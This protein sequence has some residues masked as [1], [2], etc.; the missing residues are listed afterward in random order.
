MRWGLGPVFYYE[1]LLMSRRW[2]VYAARALFLLIV[3]AALFLVGLAHVAEHPHP[4]LQDEA[5]VGERFFYA[6]I[7][8]QLVLVLL[9]A[10]AATAGSVCLDK[11]RGTLDHLL[12]TDLSDSEIVLGKLAARLLPVLGL[13]A[14]TLP[15]MALNTLLGGID[16]LALA[17]A[18]LI[19]VGVAVLGC[20]LALTLSVWGHRTHEVLLFNYALWSALLLAYPVCHF[21]A[22]EFGS[23][24]KPPT[25]LAATN[26]FWLAFAPYAAPGTIS[27]SDSALFVGACAALALLLAGVAA[28]RVRAVTLRQAARPAGQHGH[29]GLAAF[30]A[31]LWERL[32][33]SLDGNPILWR[34][35]HRKRP[36]AWVR[37]IWISYIVLAFLS[38][39]CTILLALTAPPHSARRDELPAFVNGLQLSIGLLLLSVSA[40]TSLA[41]ERVRGS[42]DVL[43]ATPLSTA[44]ILWGKWWGAYRPVLLLAILPA[45]VTAPLALQ[46][47]R[48]L[49]AGVL[50]ALTLAY[51]AAITSLGL[52]VATWIARVGRAVTACV[53]VY[54]LVTVAW[55]YAVYALSGYD[56]FPRSGLASASPF[57]GAA[58]LTV[59]I[60]GG[61]LRGVAGWDVLLTVLYLIVALILM[62]VTHA[63]FD[64]RLGRISG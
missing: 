58:L 24:W 39:G 3:L 1:C 27:L 30:A 36:S 16:P 7:G 28:A 42:L 14:C 46:T 63:A 12:V 56:D 17:G 5:A 11:A 18:F 6:L 37:F 60:G 45:L 51:G 44:S 40:A 47:S 61:Y 19:T 35:W 15:V 41:E 50:V 54:A 33:P 57:F 38:S 31:R 20:T 2:Q 8:T 59:H 34:E 25:W 21:L 23:Q 64:R 10:P 49:E 22:W 32:G 4:T 52:A 26:P 9:A 55:P 29:R 53:V 62:A 43:L 48:V 13:V